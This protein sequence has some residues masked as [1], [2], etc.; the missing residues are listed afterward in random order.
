MNEVDYFCSCLS[1][2]IH[3]EKRD[4][5]YKAQRKDLSDRNTVLRIAGEFK[6]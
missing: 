2:Y 3:G 6:E 1:F 5:A 4:S